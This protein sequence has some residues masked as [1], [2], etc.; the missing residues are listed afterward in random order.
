MRYGDFLKNGGSIGLIAPSFG[1]TFEPYRS[2]FNSAVEKLTD[3]GY[4][5]KQGPNCMKDDGIGKSTDPVSCGKEVMDFFKGDIDVLISCGGGE[6]MCEDLPFIDFEELKKTKAKLFMGY[7]DNTNLTFT[8]PVLADM[9]AIYGPCIGTFGMEKWDESIEDTFALLRGT[10]LSSHGYE[11]WEKES[12][13]TEEN[14]LAVYNLTEKSVHRNFILDEEKRLKEDNEKEISFEGRLIGGCLDSLVGLCG[15]RFDKTK[16]FIEKY[17]DDGIIWF[18]EACDLN[19]LSIRRAIWQLDNAGW[20]K[21]CKAFLIG[22]PRIFN[23]PIMGLDQYR[24]VTGQLEKYKVPVLMDLDIGHISP[25]MG[26]IS[27]AYAEVRAKG[28]EICIKH[29]LK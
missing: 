27:G 8:L 28:N 7:S 14:P 1:C 10:D 25:M 22:R 11:K 26:I 2:A 21:C 12:L 18:L 13:K 9:A 24:A 29:I 15:T 4:K 23:E 3:M 19:V 6:T 20:F 5:I 16:E 17:K